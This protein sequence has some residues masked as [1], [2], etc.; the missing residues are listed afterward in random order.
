MKMKTFQEEWGALAL[1]AFLW[2]RECRPVGQPERNG[3]WGTWHAMEWRLHRLL[4]SAVHEL[5]VLIQENDEATPKIDV[6]Q[7]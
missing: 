2:L 6:R 7:L 5:F 3:L 4:I 1:Y